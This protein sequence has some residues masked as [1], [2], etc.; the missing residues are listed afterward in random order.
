MTLMSLH[1][2][3]E[4]VP[5][6]SS[7]INKRSVWVRFFVQ[8][9]VDGFQLVGSMEQ[10]SMASCQSFD[11]A[12]FNKDVLTNVNVNVIFLF[13]APYSGHPCKHI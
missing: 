6:V 1:A 4:S 9:E 5:A 11:H 7:K 13:L 12:V 10:C 2:F 3:L 8:K